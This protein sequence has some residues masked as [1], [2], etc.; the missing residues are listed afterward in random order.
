MAV[1]RL[2]III[3]AFVATL[4]CSSFAILAKQY[5]IIN[6][7][8]EVNG[9]L[10]CSTSIYTC[11]SLL[12]HAIFKI[13]T[14]DPELAIAGITAHINTATLY[15]T[16]DFTTQT[17]EID[18]FS[19]ISDISSKDSIV[20]GI[21]RQFRHVM[22]DGTLNEIFA[23]D[24]ILKQIQVLTSNYYI[25]YNVVIVDAIDPIAS[26]QIPHIDKQ[27]AV[28]FLVLGDWGKGGLSGDITVVS[29]SSQ[30]SGSQAKSPSKEQKVTYTYQ[31]A[32]ARSMSKYVD[33]NANVVATFALGDNFYNNGVLSTT[34]QTW[35]LMWKDVYPEHLRR[36]PWYAVLG[37]HDYGYGQVSVLSEIARELDTDDDAWHMPATNYTMTF[38][39]NDQEHILVVFIDTT[40]LAPSE[41]K[42]C[43]VKG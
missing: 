25:D 26:V 14:I 31:A 11:E 23:E 18:I 43:N 3:L 35:Q 1:A 36:I 4:I 28:K 19:A 20:E 7:G 27:E 6:S 16:E 21:A 13:L 34:D 12:S 39:I 37:N 22:E 17:I 42:C 2:P 5:L 15:N 33:E 32:V 38:P 9:L 29:K 30:S 24:S 10:S 41:N 8:I 40:T